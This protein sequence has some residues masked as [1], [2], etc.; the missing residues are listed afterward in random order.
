MTRD[1]LTDPQPGDVVRGYYGCGDD[2]DEYR[3]DSRDGASVSWECTD[4]PGKVMAGDLSTW[5][6]WRMYERME[7]VRLGD[8]L[9]AFRLAAEAAEAEVRALTEA[10]EAARRRSLE[11]YAAYASAVSRGLGDVVRAL[12]VGR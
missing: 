12:E 10:L 9:E 4:H 2:F 3:V 6:S 7:V 8:S 1:P 11:A 5:A